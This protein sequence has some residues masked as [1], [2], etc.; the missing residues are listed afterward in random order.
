MPPFA[1]EPVSGGQSTG[2]SGPLGDPGDQSRRSMEAIDVASLRRPPA[3]APLPSGPLPS[4]LPPDP[5]APYPP[6]DYGPQSEYGQQGDFSPPANYPPPATYASSGSPMSAPTAAVNTIQ[7]GL[8]QTRRPALA[9][10][11]AVLVVLF[12][13]PA[14]RLLFGAA[15]ADTVVA[16]S[17]VAGTFLVAGLPAFAYGMYALLGGA[18]SLAAGSGLRVWART[19]LVYLPIGIVLFL[20][21]ALAA[22]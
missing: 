18:A 1:D 19:P 4:G 9:I 7:P 22:A 12:E 16:S 15:I 5:A 10:V 3:G 13:I 14:L 20:C 8:Y 21:A 11:L 6:A 2:W 17:V